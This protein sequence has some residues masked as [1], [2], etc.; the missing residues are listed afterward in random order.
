M[1]PSK[2]LDPLRVLAD[3]WA[4]RQ[5]RLGLFNRLRQTPIGPNRA[6]YRQQCNCFQN[7]LYHRR[8]DK[9]ATR[10]RLRY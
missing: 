2:H 1:Y 9:Q 3:L 5:Y 10:K 6:E 4:C 8:V 7:A